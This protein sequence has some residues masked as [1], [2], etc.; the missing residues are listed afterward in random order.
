MMRTKL[1]RTATSAATI[2]LV[3]GA[4]LAPGALS[5]DDGK[6]VNIYSARKEALILPILE[7]FHEETGIEFHLM[8]GRN[9]D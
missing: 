6:T 1:I 2:A 9:L 5:A 3:C 7:R 4:L 8:T